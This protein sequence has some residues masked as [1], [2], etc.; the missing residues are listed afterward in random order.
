MRCSNLSRI[1]Q[2]SVLLLVAQ[3]SHAVSAV[4][5]EKLKA[6][7]LIHIGEYTTWPDEKKQ[8]E[9][10]NVCLDAESELNQ[11]LL[12]VKENSYLIKGKALHIEHDLS[13]IKSCHIFY[14]D[15]NSLK[16]F[17]RYQ[18]QIAS[19]AVL[20]ISSER[21]FTAQGGDIQYYAEDNKIRMQV[22]LNALKNANLVIS[23]QILKLM[24]LADQPD[25]E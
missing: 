23:S 15:S 14:V 1:C 12:E 17:N 13:D 25:N 16:Y 8:L 2:T 20:T 21:D 5:A 4:P 22:S 24:K 19:Y 18:K 7:Y 10:F 11:P 6:V 9:T 3:F